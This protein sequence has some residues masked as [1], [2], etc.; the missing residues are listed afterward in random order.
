M[1]KISDKTK[2]AIIAE[3]Q[4]KEKN[5]YK[6]ILFNGSFLAKKCVLRGVTADNREIILKKV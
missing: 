5:I 2:E 4:P 3:Y 1:A 6:I